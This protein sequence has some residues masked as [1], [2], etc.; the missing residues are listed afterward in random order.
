MQS[1]MPF[2]EDIEDALKD[3][4]RALG[5]VKIVAGTLWPDKSVRDGSNLLNSCLNNARP[6]KLEI[7][8]LMWIFS[9]AKNAGCNAP[10]IW[11]A[12]EVGYD[13]KPINKEETVDRLTSTI[14][15]TA[16]ILADSLAQLESI[17]T[18]QEPRVV[19]A[20]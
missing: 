15:K 16:K 10:F 8:Q 9:Q 2:F 19:R 11:F 4:V 13:A 12:N 1:E 6:E 20:A 18:R 3:A 17:R 14:E 5:G 7:S